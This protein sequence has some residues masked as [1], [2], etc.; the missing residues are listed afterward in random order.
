MVYCAKIVFNWRRVEA[1]TNLFLYVTP[2][3]INDLN[4][5]VPGSCFFSRSK[6][7]H[8]IVF[9]SFVQFFAVVPFHII[10]QVL[11]RVGSVSAIALGS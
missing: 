11:I 1:V 6:L 5:C 9:H 2:G 7:V 3:F 4:I 10:S 8:R